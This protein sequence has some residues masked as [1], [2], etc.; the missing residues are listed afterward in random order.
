MRSVRSTT[1][2]TLTSVALAASLVVAPSGQA[3]AAGSSFLGSSFLGSSSNSDTTS[4]KNSAPVST[5]YA[6]ADSP[7]D[8]DAVKAIAQFNTDYPAWYTRN[9][10]TNNANK[11][12]LNLQRTVIKSET[13]TGY[14][15]AWANSMA[16]K[17]RAS[18][19]S[20][21]VDRPGGTSAFVTKVDAQ[22]GLD[23]TSA[24]GLIDMIA[25]SNGEAFYQLA[26]D[27]VSQFGIGIAPNSEGEYFVAVY[28]NNAKSAVFKNTLDLNATTLKNT[29]LLGGLNEVRKA[30]G[31]TN[32]ITLDTS[33]NSKA[34]AIANGGTLAASGN[35]AGFSSIV[36]DRSQAG[37][38]EGIISYA[39]SSQAAYNIVTTKQNL[40]VGI[41]YTEDE[42]GVPYAKYYFQW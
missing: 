31:V 13:L 3:W 7:E 41:A 33:L 16:A 9:Y 22:S 17:N 1:A 18:V 38:R 32:T 19:P 36:M 24:N 11:T 6:T 14:A 23:I 5:T 35:T 4:N 20:L 12:W 39:A 2:Y 40:R 10:A 27:S 37:V 30:A 15:Q 8:A 25:N 29:A 42:K 26:G 28:I 21:P 34:E